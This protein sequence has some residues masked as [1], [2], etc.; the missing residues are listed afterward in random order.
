M[1]FFE[2]DSDIFTEFESIKPYSGRLLAKGDQT[3]MLHNG[4]SELPVQG[5]FFSNITFCIKNNDVT[6]NHQPRRKKQ[7]KK[8]LCNRQN[9]W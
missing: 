2:D 7:T 3:G 6:L 9:L 5:E 4:N 1:R 8:I